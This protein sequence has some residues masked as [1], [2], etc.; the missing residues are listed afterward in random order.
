MQAADFGILKSGTCNLEA[1]FYELPFI[2]FYKTSAFS[3]WIVRKF[4]KIKQYSLVNLIRKNSIKELIQ[5][6]FNSQNIIDEIDNNL[7]DKT[8]RENLLLNLK[9]VKNKLSGFDNQ[10]NFNDCKTASERAGKI[11]IKKALEYNPK[12]GIFSRILKYLKPYKKQF[13]LALIC[14]VIFGASDGAVPLIIKHI[15]DGVFGSKD[16]SLLKLLPF[17]LIGFSLI[18]AAADYGQNFIMSK[19]GH[20]IVKDIRSET[21]NHLVEMS[22]GYFIRNSV[23]SILSRFTSDVVL[24]KELLTSSFASV[25]RDSIRIVALLCT[26]LYLDPVLA[27]IA[28]VVFPI[29]IFPVYYFGKSMRKLS[30]RGQNQI[31]AV[32]SLIQETINGIKIVKLFGRE[33]YEAN[34]FNT[35]NTNLT[36]TFIKSERVKALTGPVNEILGSIVIVGII[37]YGGLTVVNG[38]RSQGDF[39]AFL[40]SV[41]LLYDPFKKLSRVNN[42]VQQGVAGAERIF[43]LIDIK[44]DIQNIENP[45]ALPKS[46]QI[47]F[48][49]VNF[50]YNGEEDVLKNITLDIK[51]GKKIAFVGFSGAGKTTL[52]DLIPRF[53]DPQSGIIKIG[54]INI[55]D[56]DLQELRSKISMVGQHTFLFNDT[57][58]NNIKYG[59]LDASDEEVYSAA[60]SAY[61]YDFIEGFPNGFDTIVGESG[62][63][64]SGGER[65][66]IAIARAILKNAPIL[67]LDEATASLDNRSEKEIQAALEKL[68]KGKTSLVIAHRLSTVRNADEIIVMEDGEIV[69]KGT[70]DELLKKDGIFTKLYSMGFSNEPISNSS[71]VN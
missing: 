3:A 22:P 35:E 5:E 27:L 53:M 38:S 60:K 65:Q 9:E 49:D 32:S 56:L 42:S 20:S 55:K 4:I 70:H 71:L 44:P 46:N 21:Q 10:E 34:R 25:I 61:A 11:C 58:K 7:L 17:I 45:I 15:L 41:F 52:V 29:G 12:K 47:E 28:F 8:N 63:S 62:L 66:R 67:I 14:M 31:G 43:E 51:E 48:E 26:A 69:E 57:I 13:T 40:L 64:L 37:S 18:R 24:I 30:K 16:T 68:G 33:K 54:N 59:N 39:I 2:S 36:N 1:A 6:D 19:I 23:G 50:S